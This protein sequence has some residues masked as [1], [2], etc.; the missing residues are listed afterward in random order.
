MILNLVVYIIVGTRIIT[1][2]TIFGALQS[3]NNIQHEENAQPNENIQ[4]ENIVEE[5]AWASSL[6][7]SHMC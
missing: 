5:C 6:F 1:S 2:W 4:L 7:S 3:E